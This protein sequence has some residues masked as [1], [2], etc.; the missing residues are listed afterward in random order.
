MTLTRDEIEKALPANLK[1]AATQ[2][3]TDMVNNVVSDPLVA[4]QIRNNFISYAA[5]MKD[6][7]FKTEDYLHAVVY[8]SYKLMGYSNRES[9]EKTFPTRMSALVAKGTA[10]KDIAAYVSA[11]HKGKLVNLIMEQSL[12]PSWVLNQHLY[13]EAIN[14]QADLMRTANSEKVRT[15]AA[16]SLLT[17]LK[18]PEV[19]K[20][21]IDM[22]VKDS[23]G[24]TELKNTLRDLAQQQSELIAT[25]VTTREIAATPLITGPSEIVEGEF[26]EHETNEAKPG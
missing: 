23:S 13:Q 24:M 1:S 6:G 14:T 25:G 18:K 12:V 17:H 15:E 20:F 11:Y 22:E 9:Y 3:L 19:G 8:V 21:Q 16:N 2:S 4:D 5:V 7:K 10:Q 26:E